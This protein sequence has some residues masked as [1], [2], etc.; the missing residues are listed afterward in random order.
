MGAYRSLQGCTLGALACLTA[1]TIPLHAPW[2]VNFGGWLC[3]EDWF[4]SGD[5]GRYV[6][7]PP[8]QEVGQGSCLPPGVPQTTEPWP[9]EGILVKR[10]NATHGPAKTI[11]FFTGHRGSYIG[12]DDFDKIAELG[13]RAIRLPITWAAFADALAYI[14]PIYASFNPNTEAAVVPDP[15]YSDTHAL[16]TIPRAWLA[17]MIR[18]AG[19]YGLK[20][21]IDLH[22]MPGGSS[23]GTYNGIWPSPPKFWNSNATLRNK[24]ATLKEAGL[25]IAGALIDWVEDL[26]NKTFRAVVGLTL[27]NEPGHQSVGMKPRYVEEADILD[28]LG[29]AADIFR[30]SDLVGYGVKLYM[31]IIDTAFEDFYKTVTPWFHRTFSLKEQMRW[32]VMDLHWYTSWSA[33]TCDGRVIDG[34]GYKCGDPVHEVQAKLERCVI[35]WAQKFHSNFKGLKSCS[36]FSAGSYQDSRYAC[37]GEMMLRMF[38]RTQVRTM[39]MYDIEPSFWSWRMPYGGVSEP[40]WS[41]KHLSGSEATRTAEVCRGL[42]SSDD[43]GARSPSTNPSLIV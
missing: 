40:G 41:L 13:I 36:E 38:L 37:N 15:F 42:P 8:E 25:A 35:P 26:D 43:L 33:G 14:D 22:A 30:Q 2:G 5:T 11:E 6:S 21:L 23:L 27:M 3:L 10:L 29:K 39:E 34:G 17:E 19:M 7:T 32:A 9:S 16:V 1:A 4:F 12:A 18:H 28:W 20:V 31:N 24:S